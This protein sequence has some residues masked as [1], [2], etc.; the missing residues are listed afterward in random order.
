MNNNGLPQGWGE[1]S[2]NENPWA[3]NPPPKLPPKQS[4]PTSQQSAQPIQ[5]TAQT[6]QPIQQ[7]VQSAQTTEN[8]SEPV[9]S[10]QTVS[11]S[12]SSSGL[13]KINLLNVSLPNIP[14]PKLPSFPRKA[15]QGEAVSGSE[16]YDV[17]AEM[18]ALFEEEEMPIQTA[19][20]VEESN[21]IRQIHQDVPKKKGNPLVV[22]FV[23][24]ILLLV[25]IG[26]YFGYGYFFGED[27]VVDSSGGT[28]GTSGTVGSS[29]TV[30]ESEPAIVAP[31]DESW[32]EAY[33]D[34][35]HEWERQ[36]EK[37]RYWLFYIDDNDVPELYIWFNRLYTYHEDNVILLH[38]NDGEDSWIFEGYVEKEGKIWHSL[39][40]GAT[41]FQ[42]FELENGNYNLIET[43]YCSRDSTINDVA[44]SVEEWERRLNE[45][46]RGGISIE[47][48]DD[49]KEHFNGDF[50]YSYNDII[51]F[52]GG[53]VRIDSA[54]EPPTESFSLNQSEMTD[55]L[56]S[57]INI[58]NQGIV[59]GGTLLDLDFDGVPEFLVYHGERGSY[60]GYVE[61][62]HT[63]V[64]K[65]NEGGLTEIT[66]LN[67]NYS[68]G[69]E[70]PHK[71]ISLYTDESGKK[72]WAMPYEIINGNIRDYKFSL[73]DF[74]GSSVQ[75]F[76]KFSVTYEGYSYREG[77]FFYNGQ[78]LALTPE[79]IRAYQEI[80]RR[81]EIELEWY[82]RNE[83]DYLL[84]S[85]RE[86]YQD[87]DGIEYGVG[88]HPPENLYVFVSREVEFFTSVSDKWYVLKNNFEDT[89]RPNAYKLDPNSSWG[90]QNDNG[91]W[92]NMFDYE[93]RQSVSKLV[94]AYFTNDMDYL[95][96]D[97]WAYSIGAFGKP[98]IYLYPEETTDISV[99]MHFPNGC[100]NVT[101][102]DYGNGWNVTAHPDGTLINHAD[103][104]EYSYLYWDGE[105]ATEWDFSTGF[106][107]KGSDTAK[108]FQEKLAYLGLTPREY[109]EF[110]VYW[111]PKMQDNPYN[112]ISFQ[113]TVYEES[114]RLYVSPQPDS[115]LRVFMTFIALDK[116]I[117]IPEQKLDS[118]NRTGF[119][120]I[121]WGGIQVGG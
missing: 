52:L 34:V 6:V 46:T 70:T 84:N 96:N 95:A 101:Y 99:R 26:G 81:Y 113:T 33:L 90:Q 42:I 61:G 121:E 107:I 12:P 94:T 60:G 67:S 43:F 5:Q 87:Y 51:T 105:T 35:I 20:T 56:M 119:S 68:T 25:G 97:E 72:H 57:H 63:K 110:I 116:E 66:T 8:T 100:F 27:D 73:Y 91:H 89:L 102:P 80:Y 48:G 19:P 92:N 24:A 11:D 28:A 77:S 88:V 118:F 1:Q 64:Y 10:E 37:A 31:V 98:V 112:L 29:G 62:T 45:H 14:K 85:A 65:L 38:Q 109:N 58:W 40:S 104:H 83:Y 120:V 78:P 3:N 55:Y 2:A 74:T 50:G 53:E 9:Y 47:Y 22:P 79:E 18:S 103:G 23:V 30:T 69:E 32:K 71:H 15:V 106:V 21:P 115:M 76:V 75:E 49:F 16:E 82:E 59:I 7:S 93:L 54:T 111:L 36:Y 13:P 117:D 4:I 44:V 17:T 114:A 41:A 108:F 39:N 86:F